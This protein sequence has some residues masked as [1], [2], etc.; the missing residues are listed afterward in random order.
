MEIV[1]T[2]LGYTIIYIS[3][4][5]GSIFL[6][7]KFNKKIEA[8]IAIDILF[9][10]IL[11]YIFGL[12]NLLYIGSIV[13]I[14]IS[15]ILGI[16][17]L[18]KQRKNAEFKEKILT[19]VFYFFTIIYFAFM[20]FTYG[21]TSWLWDEYSHWSLASKEMFYTNKLLP[22]SG[23]LIVK[24]PPFPTILQYLFN[25]TIGVYSQGTEIFANYILGFSLLL[26]LFEN[27][28]S[29]S[30]MQNIC[31]AITILCI[32]AIFHSIIFYEGIYVD[33]ILGLLIGYIFY[34]VYMQKDS[35]FLK[36]SL[37]LAFITMSLTKATGLYIA[38]ILISSYILL[39]IIQIV[40][41]KYNI[42]KYIIE[43]KRKII[44]IVILIVILMLTAL[45]W[46][47]Y[48]N[49][50][51]G[52]ITA[53]QAYRKEES[54][55]KNLGIIEAA[56]TTLTTLLGSTEKSADYD[57]SNR[58]LFKELTTQ[59]SLKAPIRITIMYVIIFMAIA[60]IVLYKFINKEEKNK[61]KNTIIAILIGLILYIAFLQLAY[62]VK[63]GFQE[64]I[65]HASLDRYINTY[66]LGFFIL[67]VSI[68]IRKIVNTNKN[69]KYILTIFIMCILL[70][71]QIQQITDAT[72]ASGTYN[73]QM[74]YDVKDMNEMAE[75]LKENLADGERV[76]VVNQNPNWSLKETYIKYIL[77]PKFKT[78]VNP[79]LDKELAEKLDGDILEV[80]SEILIQKY[81]YIYIYK[82]DEYFE[83][84]TKE[85][86]EEEIKE[87][88]IYKIEKQEDNIKFIKYKE[89]PLD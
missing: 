38:L 2:I 18:I 46:K 30:K 84:M 25:R 41:K 32:P 86:F 83:E 78:Q 77:A 62:L 34:Q 16:I 75:F 49:E 57:Q 63:F 23:I 35:R 33:A 72:I 28:N 87:N 42:K 14:T 59:Y 15:I 36:L 10:M 89:K 17:T 51:Q 4:V 70:I 76:Y 67:L 8:C 64:R 61:Y 65:I 81:D 53:F 21:K 71:T 82:K 5:F 88:I 54:E 47:I 60:S 9:K 1:R 20:I 45:S 74:R 85:L 69:Q 66:L 39:A 19:N 29:K 80:W 73:A 58:L 43:N 55:E 22:E 7:N 56:G 40:I 26:P 24:Y 44:S 52:T 68:I 48:S 3:I 11:M 6:A 13:A 37:L 50:M 12:C 79:R 27:I 31:I